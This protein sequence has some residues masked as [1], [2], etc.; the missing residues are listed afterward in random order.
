MSLPKIYEFLIISLEPLK[1]IDPIN[2]TWDIIA[3]RLLN[4]EF[5]KKEKVGANEALINL[6]HSYELKRSLNLGVVGTKY[7]AFV[8]IVG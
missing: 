8:S 3:I 6:L 1:S 5:M 7:K 4:E 2:L